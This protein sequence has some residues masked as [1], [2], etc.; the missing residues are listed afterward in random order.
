MTQFIQQLLAYFRLSQKAVCEQSIG[1]GLYNDYHDYP[2]DVYGQPI[3]MHD[4]K[5][6]HCGKLFR[7]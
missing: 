3:H 5:C 7:I 6:K 4:L 2:D 1:K